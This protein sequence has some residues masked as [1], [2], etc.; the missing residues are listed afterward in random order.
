[1]QAIF[2]TLRHLRVS[3]V[4][5][6]RL[7]GFCVFYVG[8]DLLW[9]FLVD[10]LRF[11]WCSLSYLDFLGPEHMWCVWWQRKLIADA[12][13]FLMCRLLFLR[14][15]AYMSRDETVS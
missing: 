8:A 15:D 6:P 1:M 4:L 7:R 14:G 13:F 12:R 3:H 10:V 9:Q 11:Q 2:L 5:F